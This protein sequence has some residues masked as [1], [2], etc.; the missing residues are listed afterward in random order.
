MGHASDYSSSK[1]HL[2]FVGFSVGHRRI[3]VDSQSEF[4]ILEHRLGAQMHIQ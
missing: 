1:A 2:G 4:D 3:T